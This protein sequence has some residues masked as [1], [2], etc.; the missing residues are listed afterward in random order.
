MLRKH[1]FVTAMQLKAATHKDKQ[2]VLLQYVEPKQLTS[3]SLLSER[4]PF[5]TAMQWEAAPRR[6]RQNMWQP[7]KR[8]AWSLEW[9]GMAP[10]MR[11]HWHRY[12][13][14]LSVYEF[15]MCI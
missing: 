5:L 1:P 15:S 8:K 11:Q 3:V 9:L 10:T 14:V 13:N 4:H 7:C 2:N 6:R 12:P